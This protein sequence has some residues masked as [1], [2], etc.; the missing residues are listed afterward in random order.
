MENAHT[1]TVQKGKLKIM[2]GSNEVVQ[3]YNSSYSE[4]NIGKIM[5]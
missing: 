1:Y 3:A 5:V 4:S 2:L